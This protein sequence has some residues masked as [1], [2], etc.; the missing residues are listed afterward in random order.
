MIL[1]NAQRKVQDYNSYDSK[2]A[3]GRYNQAYK[4][5]LDK[6][7]SRGSLV[8]VGGYVDVQSLL[9]IEE[10]LKAFD[11]GRQMDARFIEKLRRK[12]SGDSVKLLLEEFRSFSILS[13][14]IESIKEK[15]K[16]I[17]ELLRAGGIDG[18][19]PNG[20]KFSV[21]AT[22]IMN[23]MFPNLFV[24][25]D[26]WVRRAHNQQQMSFDFGDYWG[27]MLSC[28]NELLKWQKVHGGLDS[29][30]VLDN[31]PTTPVRVFDK[32]AFITGKFSNEFT[33]EKCPKC[34][35]PLKFRTAKRT[36]ERYRGCT[37][38]PACNHNER[39]Y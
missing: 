26:K 35:F 25:S 14:D 34:G 6:V 10:S 19:S 20:D 2:K 39:S 7:A 15:I 33:T 28:R 24:I 23:F 12:L 27:I 4:A 11:M 3:N 31:L 5:I 22:K 17:F 37:N 21:G 1:D 16:G 8:D 32:C 18:F 29:L 9:A 13:Q 30:I 36:G 38:Y